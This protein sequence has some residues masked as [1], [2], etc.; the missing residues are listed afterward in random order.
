MTPRVVHCGPVTCLN[1]TGMGEPGGAEH[2]SAIGA[3]Y[4][5]AA[6]MGGAASPLEGRWWVEDTSRQPLEVPRDQW[7][8]HLLLPLPATP[9]PGA[10]ESARERARASC[11]AVD[12]VQVVTFTEGECV[13]LLHEGPYDEEKASLDVMD[14]FMAEHG[15]ARNGPHHE[16]YLTA[17]T[18]PEPRTILRQPVTR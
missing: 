16:I 5:V 11:A 10:A 9:E 13:E 6:A 18:D 3:L 17:F 12:R 1:V 14:A 4:A 2:V 8:W 15:F 7:R